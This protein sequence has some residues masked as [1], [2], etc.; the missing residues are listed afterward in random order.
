M[1]LRAESGLNIS[2][3]QPYKIHYRGKGRFISDYK[4]AKYEL[5]NH[6]KNV[7]TRFS[8]SDLAVCWVVG[9]NSQMRWFCKIIFYWIFLIKKWL[10]NRNFQSSVEFWADKTCSRRNTSAKNNGAFCA[11]AVNLSR[12]QNKNRWTADPTRFFLWSLCCKKPQ[13]W[14]RK[15]DSP[16]V[17]SRLVGFSLFIRKVQ[18]ARHH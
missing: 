9:L 7:G 8:A 18:I 10:E 6:E 17:F 16:P 4:G 11:F 3:K 12:N 13:Q 2:A 5:H 15:M 1:F 14:N